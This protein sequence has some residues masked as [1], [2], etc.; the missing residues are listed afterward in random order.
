MC[1][2]TGVKLLLPLYPSEHDGV[3]KRFAQDS[4]VQKLRCQ[5]EVIV[6]PALMKGSYSDGLHSLVPVFNWSRISA[7]FANHCDEY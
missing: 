7:P 5:F 4:S 6:L 2:H 1:H 3:A